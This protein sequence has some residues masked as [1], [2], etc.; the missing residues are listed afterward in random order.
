MKKVFALL[1]FLLAGCATGPSSL[2]PQPEPQSLQLADIEARLIRLERILSNDS[3][4]QLANQINQLQ[5]EIQSLR[6]EVETQQFQLSGGVDRQRQLYLDL[7]NRLQELEQFRRETEIQAPVVAITPNTI[8]M[9]EPPN[10]APASIPSD[11][12]SYNQAYALLQSGSYAQAAS[13]FALFLVDYPNSEL[14]DNAQYWL[15]ETY[16][17]R[18]QYEDALAN[19]EVMLNDFPGSLKTP[20]ALLKI[21]FSHHGLGNNAQAIDAL[22][23]VVSE[24]P[25]TTAARLAQQRMDRI[26]QE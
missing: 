2:T 25:D 20:D 22:S 26:T 7:D 6:G 4:I 23:V 17:A 10:V 8:A 12:E 14:S 15:A 19:F 3:L 5:Q 18:R 13:S 1:A 21:G 24:Y 11:Q 9:N 16:Y